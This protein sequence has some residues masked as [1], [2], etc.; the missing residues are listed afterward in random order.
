MQGKLR[1]EEL[2]H[3]LRLAYIAG[4]ESAPGRYEATEQVGHR[5]SG[6]ALK[7]AKEWMASHEN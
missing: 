2:E 3:W 5:A 4:F 1:Q 7:A 6:F